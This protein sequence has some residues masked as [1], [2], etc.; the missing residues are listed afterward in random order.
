MPF[1]PAVVSIC[2]ADGYYYSP[3]VISTEPGHVSAVVVR[4]EVMNSLELSFHDFLPP[5]VILS[6]RNTLEYDFV[7]VDA[8][9]RPYGV[10]V[11][12]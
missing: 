10:F 7:H 9:T 8:L 6:G 3:D 1:L 2:E 4:E 11:E 5:S 12:S